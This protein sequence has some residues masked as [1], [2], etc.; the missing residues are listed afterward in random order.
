MALP[1]PST[2]ACMPACLYVQDYYF[3]RAEKKDDLVQAALGSDCLAVPLGG[4][5][6]TLDLEHV[7]QSVQRHW[8]VFS[9][10]GSFLGYQN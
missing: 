5:R 6:P 1:L 3:Y 4:Q 9:S 7:K 2:D 10:P 8:V